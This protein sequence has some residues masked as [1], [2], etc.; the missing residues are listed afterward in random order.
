MCG[1]DRCAIMTA[2]ART[3]APAMIMT[4]RS[5]ANCDQWRLGNRIA[6]WSVGSASISTSGNLAKSSIKPAA[7]FRSL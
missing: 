4:I 1:I 2:V 6:E 7:I 5:M 3:T